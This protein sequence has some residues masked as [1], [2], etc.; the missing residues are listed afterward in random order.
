MNLSRR[1]PERIRLRLQRRA[2]RV[3]AQRCIHS[4]RPLKIEIGSIGH[5][6]HSGDWIVTN[7]P[8]F[9]ALD[10]RQW[11]SLFR[12]RSVDRVLAE[13]VVEHW[14]LAQLSTFLGI[15]RT[16]LA[17]Q[18]FLR[19]AV[20]DGRHPD[21]SYISAV[22]PGGSGAGAED[23]KVLYTHE[24]IAA[25]CA[26]AGFEVRLVEYFDVEGHFHS[27]PWDTVDGYINRSA[28]HDSRNANGELAYTSLI[29]DAFPGAGSPGKRPRDMGLGCGA[30]ID[31]KCGSHDT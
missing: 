5:P 27:A 22:Q 9:D 14:T 30:P 24:S 16:Y 19:M 28:A 21:P 18:G 8:E 1:V 10:E 11:R 29:V 26:S 2:I 31:E 20:P 25:A 6:V 13:H 15:L 4:H 3:A 17:P 23:H 12:P 7:L